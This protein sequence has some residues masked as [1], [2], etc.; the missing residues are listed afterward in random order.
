[1][2]RPA[3]RH[4]EYRAHNA[5]V[6]TAAICARAF[7]THL[8]NAEKALR[9]ESGRH[10]PSANILPVL[11]SSPHNP[12]ATAKGTNAFFAL[13]PSIGVGSGLTEKLEEAQLRKIKRY[14]ER[15]SPTPRRMHAEQS[16]RAVIREAN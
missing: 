1:M 2:A 9:L 16:G 5:S 7:E 11:A 14:L 13:P 6:H 15:L 4:P 12:G 8:R 3:E 10:P